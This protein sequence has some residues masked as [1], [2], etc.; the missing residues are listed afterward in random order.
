[1]YQYTRHPQ[2]KTD[3]NIL[4]N[5][6]KRKVLQYRQQAWDDNLSSLNAEDN[7]LWEVAKAFRKKP[8]PPPTNSV[9][10]VPTGT[11]LSDTNK[12]KLITKSLKSQLQPDDIHNPRADPSRY[13]ARAPHAGVR[14][15][16]S[17]ATYNSSDKAKFF[18]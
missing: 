13:A 11:A 1:M 14:R 8:P 3:L 7:F 12:T 2:H 9:L 4:Q 5:I 16:R 18:L 6:I 10:N 17:Q 15:G